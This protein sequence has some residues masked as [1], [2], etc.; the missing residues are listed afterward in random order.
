MLVA[1]L[2][3]TSAVNVSARAASPVVSVSTRSADK[4]DPGLTIRSWLPFVSSRC[5]PWLDSVSVFTPVAK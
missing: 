5:S 1:A 3:V 2:T 4:S